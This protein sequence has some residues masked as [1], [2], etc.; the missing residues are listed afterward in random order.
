[1]PQPSAADRSTG[2]RSVTRLE[3]Q[4]LPACRLEELL[5]HC[6][7]VDSIRRTATQILTPQDTWG[8][9]AG[10][11]IH[12]HSY[13]IDWRSRSVRLGETLITRMAV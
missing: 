3:A 12:S 6:W 4:A 5:K 7:W 13:L 9:A 1:M 8:F 10:S 2:A 11:P